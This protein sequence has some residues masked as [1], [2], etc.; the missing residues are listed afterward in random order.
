MAAKNFYT[1]DQI[2]LAKM[3]LD[4]LPDLS[5]D[6]ISSKDALDSLRTQIV[7]LATQK[8]YSAKEIKSAL[9]TCEIVVSE[10]AIRDMLSASNGS[11]KKTTGKSKKSV[12]QSQN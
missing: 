11:K 9:E 8:G 2:E 1:H 5:K 4:E 7:V 12:N 6:K 3:K 10:R